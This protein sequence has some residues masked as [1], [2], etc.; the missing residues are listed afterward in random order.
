M[1]EPVIAYRDKSSSKEEQVAEEVEE[2][3][4]EAPT[5]LA[6]PTEAEPQGEDGEVQKESK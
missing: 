4:E 3:A 1:S 6:T 2:V 5:D